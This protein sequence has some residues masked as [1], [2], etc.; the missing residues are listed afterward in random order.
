MKLRSILV[1][2]AALLALGVCSANAALDK[3]GKQAEIDKAVQ[4]SLDKFYNARPSIKTEVQGAPGYAG[5]SGLAQDKSGHK[6]YMNM[7]QASAGLQAGA[8]ERDMLVVFKTRK[9]LQNFIAK[10]WEASGGAGASA[11]AGGKSAGGGGGA[12]FISDADYY[13]LTK[14]GLEVGGALAGTKFWK[15]KELN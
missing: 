11:G 14:N 4:A 3:A 10:G 5:G 9:A 13:L 7:A 6:T 2:C 12:Q 8:A 15:D 1:A